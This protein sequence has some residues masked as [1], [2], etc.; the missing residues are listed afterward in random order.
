MKKLILFLFA[1]MTTCSVFA[2]REPLEPVEPVEP[3]DINIYEPDIYE[4]T[5]VQNDWD[6]RMSPGIGYGVF[7]SRD[8]ETVGVFHGI[9]T[10]LIFFATSSDNSY[11]GP[12][13]LRIYGR[14]NMMQSLENSNNGLFTYALGASMSFERSIKRKFMIPYYGIEIGAMNRTDK[15]RA[16]QMTTLA[17]V[18]LLAFKHF[19]WYV[20]GGYTF[21]ASRDF[22]SI[23]GSFA[24]SGISVSFW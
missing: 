21:A 9:N 18:N 13:Y 5:K 3:V 14:L 22:N 6:Q 16:F 7:I 20:Q 8:W 11:N 15:D 24:T 1:I 4:P 12:G 17:G 2:Q 19:T 10:E 23:S